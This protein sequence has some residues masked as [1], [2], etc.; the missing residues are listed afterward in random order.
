[1][2]TKFSMIAGCI[3][4]HVD[5]MYLAVAVTIQVNLMKTVSIPKDPNERQKWIDAMPN[6]RSRLSQ[7]SEIHVCESH[8]QNHYP[9]F[10]V[11]H[12]GED[13]Y[14]SMTNS[15]GRQVIQFI[16]FRHVTSH[17]GFLHL[18]T[19]EKEGRQIPKNNFSLQKNSLLSKW[20]QVDEVFLTTANY[21][22]C[23]EVYVK[24]ALNSL[25]LMCD[26]RDS[27][28]FQ[29]IRTQLRLLLLTPKA[30]RFKVVHR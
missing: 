10:R 13:L 30:R 25:D 2:I 24:S 27:S 12:S 21:E 7:L 14:L 17:F 6:E 29:F 18:V 26:L 28:H 15:I 19:A 5:A 9:K 1:M 4:C 23:N 16:H 3:S 20:S 11:V 8:V 22:I